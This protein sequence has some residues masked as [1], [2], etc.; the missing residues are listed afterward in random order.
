MRDNSISKNAILDDLFNQKTGL[1]GKL[2][3]VR[4]RLLTGAIF[5]DLFFKVYIYYINWGSLVLFIIK[6]A[7]KILKLNI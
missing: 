2:F 1:L 3:S 6:V 5:F 4:N 7:N